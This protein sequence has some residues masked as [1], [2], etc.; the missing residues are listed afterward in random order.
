M[1]LLFLLAAA[2]AP[3]LAGCLAPQ[4]GLHATATSYPV[5][6]LVGWIGQGHV[7]VTAL[8]PPG[9]QLANWSPDPA[10]LDSAGGLRLLPLAGQPEP[11]GTHEDEEGAHPHEASHTHDGD[12]DARIWMDPA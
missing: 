2:V 3:L 10:A 12:L 9:T 5:A 6:F 7:E 1:R 8:V 4:A 11:E